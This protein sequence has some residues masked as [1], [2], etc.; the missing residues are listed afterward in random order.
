MGFI[1]VVAAGN[2][3]APVDFSAIGLAETVFGKL[4]AGFS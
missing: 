4:T 2:G 1:P 3:L